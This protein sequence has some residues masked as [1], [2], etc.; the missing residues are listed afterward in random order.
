MFPAINNKIDSRSHRIV[1]NFNVP[2]SFV[3][4]SGTS[5]LEAPKQLIFGVDFFFTDDEWSVFRLMYE[6]YRI[7]MMEFKFIP[8]HNVFFDNTTA[9]SA[10]QTNAT[11]SNYVIATQVNDNVS[12]TGW[13]TTDLMKDVRS[14]VHEGGKTFTLRYKPRYRRAVN[15]YNETQAAEFGSG[16]AHGSPWLG[17]P[18][19]KS[20]VPQTLN[21]YSGGLAGGLLDTTFSTERLNAEYILEM[22]ALVSWRRQL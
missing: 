18:A 12:I 6:E 20:S 17:L 7:E 9:G 5:V 4:S 16:N 19:A 2:L 14:T 22:K 8:A 11:C 1:A 15:G 21:M 3:L 13:K 10:K